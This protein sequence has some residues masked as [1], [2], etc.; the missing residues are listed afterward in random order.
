MINLFVYNLV[1]HFRPS[2]ITV[3]I[4]LKNNCMHTVWLMACYSHYNKISRTLKIQTTW[5]NLVSLLIIL[6]IILIFLIVFL[7]CLI[8]MQ[9]KTITVMNAFI[10]RGVRAKKDSCS[11]LDLHFN[12]IICISYNL[13][14]I[15]F[16]CLYLLFF[17]IK[18]C[19]FL[20]QRSYGGSASFVIYWNIKRD[21]RRNTLSTM[22]W[23]LPPE[24]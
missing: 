10:F 22:E 3:L 12:K 7:S 14:V 21:C 15:L 8:A 20:S 24:P 11:S 19:L 5:Q 13:R 4:S 17:N 9:Q 23:L 1:F 18:H 6:E 2:T 16:S